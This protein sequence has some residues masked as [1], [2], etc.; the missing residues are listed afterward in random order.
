M[1]DM[2]GNYALPVFGGET[3]FIGSPPA[4]DE[5]FLDML[6]NASSTQLSTQFPARPGIEPVQPVAALHTQ[7]KDFAA[8]APYEQ[9]L[10]SLSKGLDISLPQS[11][12]HPV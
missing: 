5:N 11:M 9:L 8:Q 7:R 10:P 1:Y 4:M 12:Y 6:V 3:P 2:T